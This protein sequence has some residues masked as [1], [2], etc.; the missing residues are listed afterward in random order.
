MA[1]AEGVVPAVALGVA[2]LV[3]MA[4]EEALARLSCMGWWVCLRV[5][6]MAVCSCA[7][8]ACG[9]VVQLVRCVALLGLL[10]WGDT[11]VGL[12]FWDLYHPLRWA[13][14]VSRHHRVRPWAHP[15]SLV[16]GGLLRW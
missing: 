16:C 4:K 15:F 9:D 6:L 13:M 2:L 1:E 5:Y 12:L 10:R 3:G 14:E 8:G 7:C 11:D